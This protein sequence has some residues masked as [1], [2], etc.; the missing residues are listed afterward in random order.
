MQSAPESERATQS[1]KVLLNT[2]VLLD[3]AL[4]RQPFFEDSELVLS[5]VESRQIKGAI[6]AS[7]VSDLYY[8]IRKQKKSHAL[9]LEFVD[10]I[11]KICQIATVNRA[12]IEMALTSSFDD[13]EDA[14]QYST[15]Q[16]NA[17]DGI[18]TRNPQDYHLAELRIFTPSA[19]IQYLST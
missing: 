6:S 4:E 5:L 7:T 1:I 16:I 9:A 10:E 8:V 2:N 15:A 13:F 17:L 14:I 18:V 3:I 11:S 12:V 19:L